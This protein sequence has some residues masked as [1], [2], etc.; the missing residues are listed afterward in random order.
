MLHSNLIILFLFYFLTMCQFLSFLP[1]F[2]LLGKKYWKYWFR[3]RKIFKRIFSV[4]LPSTVCHP[5]S[6]F[7]STS[8]I[9]INRFCWF[10]RL[11][12][13]RSLRSKSRLLFETFYRLLYKNLGFLDLFRMFLTS[14]N[15]WISEKTI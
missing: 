1:I 14:F 15:R 12:P 13:R 5:E 8:L 11:R 3:F 2:H 9:K 6:K 10:L 4:G 7:V